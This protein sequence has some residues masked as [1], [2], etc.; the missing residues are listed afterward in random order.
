MY[1]CANDTCDT[2]DHMKYLWVHTQG[3]TLMSRSTCVFCN[4]HVTASFTHMC[5]VGAFYM[6]GVGTKH[7]HL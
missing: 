5:V 4:V 2:F 7:L 3:K 6:Q 1:T